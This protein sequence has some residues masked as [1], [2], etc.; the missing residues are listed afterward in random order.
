M[1]VCA[2]CS[3]DDEDDAEAILLL[4]VALRRHGS[5]CTKF[6]NYKLTSLYF[7]CAVRKM[8]GL[9]NVACLN[10]NVLLCF[11]SFGFL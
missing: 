8:R 4:P 11:L 3:A 1:V 5:R 7:I 9:P 2:Y 10:D 6:G